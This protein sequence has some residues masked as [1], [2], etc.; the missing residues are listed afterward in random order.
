MWELLQI[1]D[2]PADTEAGGSL[3]RER[4]PAAA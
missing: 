3:F 2:R 1:V 4:K